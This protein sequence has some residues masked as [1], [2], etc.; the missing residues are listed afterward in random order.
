M[1]GSRHSRGVLLVLMLLAAAACIALAVGCGDDE[2]DQAADEGGTK[3][4]IIIGACISETG[5]M[6]PWDVP[7]T[8]ALDLCLQEQNAKG[9]VDGHELQLI[10]GDMK[11]DPTLGPQVA[12][13]LIDQGACMLM[14]TADFDIGAPSA[15]AASD[16]QVPAMSFCA[17]SAK[18]NVK[19]GGDYAFSMGYPAAEDGYAAAE[20][21]I[22]QGW[23]SAWVI[24]DEG[25]DYSK[26]AAKGFVEHYEAL[27]GTV[28]GSETFLPGDASI[29]TQVS[30]MKAKS[31]EYDCIFLGSFPPQGAAA[32]RQIRAAGLDQ[33]M[34]GGDGHDGDF[35]MESVP[36][37]SDWYTVDYGSIHGDDPRA[38]FNQLYDDIEK[39]FGERP[40][41]SNAACGY[42]VGQAFIKALQET[43]GSTDGPALL[44]A[45]ESF[46]D[47]PLL[48]GDTTFTTS[49]HSCQGR[50]YYVVETQ[51]G[52][53]GYLS[54]VENTSLPDLSTYVK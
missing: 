25:F 48:T 17:G 3:E 5:I 9:G 37:L 39:E 45:L 53:R 36:D 34:L 30:R 8:Q 23:T 7:A 40:I 54:T 42:S 43:G 46:K 4:P 35:W 2:S 31:D 27:G 49:A 47:V 32:I 52:T 26:H 44:K 21:A 29:A 41:A 11:G 13:E 38:E 19:A 18:Y 24:N 22:D 10:I 16:R 50:T 12:N 6:Q 20:F 14:L 33:P 28:V 1:N 51:N 15:A